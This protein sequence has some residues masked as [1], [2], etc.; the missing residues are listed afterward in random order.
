MVSQNFDKNEWGYEVH[1]VISYELISATR[2][3]ADG[4]CVVLI[5]MMIIVSRIH[6]L[7]VWWPRFAILVAVVAWLCSSQPLAAAS[8]VL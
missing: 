7:L 8:I 5:S 6:F 2:A 4:I 1:V 3:L